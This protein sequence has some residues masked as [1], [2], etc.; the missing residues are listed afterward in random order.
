MKRRFG[1]R[2]RF[3]LL[4]VVLFVVL[5]A[6]I[7]AVSVM[8]SA[9]IERSAQNEQTKSFASLATSPI[10]NTFLLY[11]DSGSIRIRQ[12]I[13]KYTDLD[14]EVSG[15]TILTTDGKVVFSEGI[16]SH[17]TASQAA[18]FSTIYQYGSGTITKVITP[19][20]ED[21]GVHRYA[22]VYGISTSQLHGNI[23]RT[24]VGIVLLSTV[25]LAVTMLLTYRLI[26]ILFLAD[27]STISRKARKISQGTFEDQIELRRQDEL[28]D[29]ARAVN[30]MANSLKAD[31][32]KLQDADKLKSEFIAISSHNLR[33]PLT[34]IKGNAE[35]MGMLGVPENVKTMLQDISNGAV[36]LETF[37]EDLLAIAHIESGKLTGSDLSVQPLKPLLDMIVEN[38]QHIDGTDDVRFVANIHLQDEQVLMSSH[39]LKIAFINML[40]NSVKFTKHGTITLSA[41]VKDGGIDIAVADT[42]IGIP[43][44]EIPKLFTKFHRGTSVLQYDYEGTGIGLY[45]TK[46]I[47]NNHD[48][49]IKVESHEGKGTTFTV[50]LPLATAADAQ[51]DASTSAKE[52]PQNP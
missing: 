31:I 25:A 34:A 30:T 41:E 13:N 6:V 19:V 10:G 17:A 45:L 51:P 8:R 24:V 9:T 35:L 40:E 16:V 23:Q 44:A 18:T 49:T 47:I 7:T 43:A 3:L 52:K 28:G 26:D 29:L 27:V 46:L 42:G 11:K 15:V 5:F 39:M 37:I 4:I 38:Y 2:Q 32:V 33:T 36:R 12:E 21:Y 22:I 20:I 50:H 48:G 1:L 14:P